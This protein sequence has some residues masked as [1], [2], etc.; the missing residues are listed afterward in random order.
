[1]KKETP[2]IVLDFRENMRKCLR[3]G[4]VGDMPD[5]AIEVKKYCALLFD[6]AKRHAN[7][8]DEKKTAI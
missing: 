3:C 8:K 2:W 1:M 6:F 7:C 4:D 5:E